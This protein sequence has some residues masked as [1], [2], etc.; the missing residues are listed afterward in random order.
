MRIPLLDLTRQHRQV[1][2]AV[3]AR[4]ATVFE[5]QQFVLGKTVEDFEQAFCA[6]FGC[7]QAVGMS[8]GTDAQLAILMAMGIGRGDAVITSPYTF[9]ATAGCI[10][11]LGAEPVFVDIRRDTMHLDVTKLEEYL[12]TKCQRDAKGTP[13]TPRGNRVRAVIPVHL[14]GSVCAMDEILEVAG[15]FQLEVVEDA[16]QAVGA[17]YPS[18][19][20]PLPSG[21]IAGSAYFS[22]FPTKNLGGAGDGGLVSCQDAAFAE[23]LRNIRNHGMTRTYH[24]ETVGGNFRLDALQAAVLHAKLPFVAGWNTARK[25]HADLYREGFRDLVASG[26]VVLPTE[27]HADSGLPGHHTYHQYVVRVKDRDAVKARL[28]EQGIGHA[29]YYPQPLHLQPCFANLGYQPGDLPES[30]LAARESLALPI[31]PELEESE[32]T[33]VVGTISDFYR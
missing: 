2:A 23:K 26:V 11:R 19:K 32:L 29:V 27:P 3:S 7:Q 20:G 22:F 6:E 21:A 33:A 28:A 14:F 16:A 18:R 15:R 12:E 31:Y 30:E 24:H 13:L 1:G 17:M 10:E 25:H 5:T 9:F 8:S 4:V